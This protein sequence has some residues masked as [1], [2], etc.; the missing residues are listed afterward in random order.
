MIKTFI[1][2]AF[3]SVTASLVYLDFTNPQV[4]FRFL[5]SLFII[6]ATVER[7]WETFYTPK[8]KDTLKFR[9]DKTLIVTI[10]TYL[11]TSLLVIFQFYATSSKNYYI[12]GVGLAIFFGGLIFRWWAINT[13]KEQW[14]IH[15]N[16][17]SDKNKLIKD[18]P[19]KYVRHPIY[20]GAILDLIG[21]ALI[22]N[23]YIYILVILCLNTPLYVWRSL[24]EEK[25]N[26]LKFGA[27]YQ[28]YKEETSFMFPWKLV[29]KRK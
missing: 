5:F 14:S 13:L 2:A 7:L 15:L 18:G 9:G 8:D 24:Y 29:I 23:A 26:D 28:K 25:I 4:Q 11:I 6:L 12:T 10:S 22:S 17:S 3:F 27:D 21:L 1:A 20:V 19:Y 16:D